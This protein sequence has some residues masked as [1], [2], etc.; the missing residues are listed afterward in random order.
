MDEH[1]ARSALELARQRFFVAGAAFALLTDTASQDVIVG[2]SFYLSEAGFQMLRKGME[3]P[4]G[5]S[6][7]ITFGRRA[8]EDEAR[9]LLE[10]AFQK[11]IS[12]SVE[13]VKAFASHKGEWPA[14]Q[15]EQWFRFA[16][17]LRNAFSHNGHWDLR[18]PRV[19]PVK[20]KRYVI[21]SGMHGQ[22]ARDFITLYDGTELQAQMILYV[23]GVVDVRQQHV[24]RSPSTCGSPMRATRRSN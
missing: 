4:N 15:N 5:N 18:N 23:T 11:L 3:R 10:L 24:P 13:A 16:I 2:Y 21:E 12:D 20:W 1:L 17:H 22:S 19:L 8:A 6:R 9:S 7:T 14:L